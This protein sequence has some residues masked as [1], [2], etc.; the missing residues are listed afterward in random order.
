M[1]NNMQPFEN[2]IR[3]KDY[4]RLID[5]FAKKIPLTVI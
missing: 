1:I 5:D 4:N 3:K 2:I